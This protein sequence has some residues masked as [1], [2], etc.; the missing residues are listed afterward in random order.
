MIVEISEFCIVY[1]IYWRF[2]LFVFDDK[3]YC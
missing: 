1:C 3:V 2:D